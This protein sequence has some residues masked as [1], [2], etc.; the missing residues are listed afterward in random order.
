M[1]GWIWGFG[2][3]RS[4]GLEG[5]L[6]VVKAAGKSISCPWTS[7]IRSSPRRVEPAG[8]ASVGHTVVC[9]L[10]GGTSPWSWA[11]PGWNLKHCKKQQQEVFRE[12]ILTA[13]CL[14]VENKQVSGQRTIRTG[15]KRVPL[16][17]L[18]TWP[19]EGDGQLTSSHV[20]RRQTTGPPYHRILK[21]SDLKPYIFSWKIISLAKH[22]ENN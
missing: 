9:M 18:Q 17:L 16:R 4:G 19:L 15:G 14:Q 12:A 22:Q 13:R 20:L 21:T 11:S 5:Q 7:G 8:V 3:Y 10:W 6:H 2:T 1:F